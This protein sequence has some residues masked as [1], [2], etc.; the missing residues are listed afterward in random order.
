MLIPKL[1][2]K[3]Y[4]YTVITNF[5]HQFFFVLRIHPKCQF[6]RAPPNRFLPTPARR[7]TEAVIDVDVLASLN[8]EN[9]NR[10]RT[11]LKNRSK[12]SFVPFQ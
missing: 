7:L 9:A 1:S 2:F 12:Q 11:G 6:V 10:F 5:Y 4:C 8:I 3:I